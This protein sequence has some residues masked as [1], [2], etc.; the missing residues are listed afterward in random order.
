MLGDISYDKA[1]L[2]S[3]G[4][5]TIHSLTLSET[6]QMFSAHTT[7]RKVIKPNNHRSFGFAFKKNLD[8]EI[9]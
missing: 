9:T 4:K 2:K 7:L 5:Q 8:R 1:T 3:E 6:H